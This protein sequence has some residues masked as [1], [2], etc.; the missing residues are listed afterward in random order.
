MFCLTFSFYLSIY[1]LFLFLVSFRFF[2]LSAG[3]SFGDD[4]DGDGDDGIVCYKG[5]ISQNGYSS[6]L[7]ELREREICVRL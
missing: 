6:L 5:E 1:P 4:G 7:K 2:P 3:N